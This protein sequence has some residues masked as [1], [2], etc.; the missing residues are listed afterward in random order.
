MSLCTAALNK[1]DKAAEQLVSRLWL[2]GRG[3][4]AAEQHVPPQMGFD[5]ATETAEQHV[6][7]LCGLLHCF[8]DF[9]EPG[10]DN[11]AATAHV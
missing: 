9:A 7:R 3:D 11:T 5:N 6:P 10:H 1:S 2:S 4:E 8:G